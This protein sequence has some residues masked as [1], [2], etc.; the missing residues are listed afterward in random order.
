MFPSSGSIF[1][2][3][4]LYDAQIYAGRG[5]NVSC[6]AGFGI[7]AVSKRCSLPLAGVGL[8]VEIPVYDLVM[9]LVTSACVGGLAVLRYIDWVITEGGVNAEVWNWWHSDDGK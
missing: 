8:M 3:V 4:I 6:Y 7:S 2:G 5:A 9:L 1:D